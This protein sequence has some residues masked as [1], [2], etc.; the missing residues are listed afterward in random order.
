MAKVLIWDIPM[1]VF[2]WAFSVC[3]SIAFLIAFTVDDDGMLF[4][5]HMLFGLAAALLLIV[6]IV[7]G[8]VGG[9]HEGLRGLIFS[10]VET[11]GYLIKAP[12]GQARRY[13]GHNPGTA[14]AALCMFA[15]VG[16]L[17]WSGLSLGKSESLEELHETMAYGLLVAVAAHVAGLIMHTFHH[18]ENIAWSMMD[19]TKEAPPESATK[20]ARPLAGLSV[21]ALSALCVYLPIRGYDPSNATVTL[22]GLGTVALGEQE[23]ENEGGEYGE[24][25][26]EEEDDD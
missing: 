12:F 13:A 9:R 25:H 10:P 20:S 1:R 2:H 15:L 22:P 7:V 17:A 3:L 8:V 11:I 5:W 19:G 18:R 26:E 21:L 6:R 16:G 23:S 24:H 4:R 14:L